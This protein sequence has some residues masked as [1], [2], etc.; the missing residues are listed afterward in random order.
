M[1]NYTVQKFI[2]EMIEN[3]Y[4]L[5]LILEDL[6]LYFKFSIQSDTLLKDTRTIQLSN[7]NEI[8]IIN[9]K[10]ISQIGENYSKLIKI[11]WNY[12]DKFKKFEYIVYCY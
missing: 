12:K 3:N 2:E 11:T 9:S 1:T 8:I 7:N 10:I 4:Y 5:E 6:E